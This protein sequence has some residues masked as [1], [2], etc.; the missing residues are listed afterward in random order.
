MAKKRRKFREKA[1]PDFKMPPTSAGTCRN[2]GKTII[3]AINEEGKKVALSWTLEVYSIVYPGPHS[4][5]L[6]KRAKKTVYVNHLLV[7]GVLE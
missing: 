1:D 4:H 2:C 7:C 5:Y 3:Y 6:T